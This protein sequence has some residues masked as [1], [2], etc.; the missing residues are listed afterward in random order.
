MQPRRKDN[1]DETRTRNVILSDNINK[2]IKL[3]NLTQTQIAQK[4][5]ISSSML[6]KKI[7]GNLSTFTPEELYKLAKVLNVYVDDLLENDK[8][9]IQRK[10]KSNKEYKP[11]EAR[12]I[13]KVRIWMSV[14]KKPSVLMIVPILLIILCAIFLFFVSKYSAFWGIIALIIPICSIIDF[15]NSIEEE[16]FTI[17]YLDD[18]YYMLDNPKFSKYKY[19]LLIHI[20]QL[21][22]LTITISLFI[23]NV[24]L[25]ISKKYNYALIFCLITTFLCAFICSILCPNIKLKKLKKK[26][27]DFD[28]YSYKKAYYNFVINGV[29]FSISMMPTGISFKNGFICSIFCLVSLCMSILEFVIVSKKFSEYDLYY[30]AYKSSPRKLYPDKYFN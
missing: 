21:V 12:K 22:F 9:K 13:N 24:D 25:N 14:F 17:D 3:S 10:V 16:S 18:V 30:E 28:V 4:L 8:E 19:V 2:Y 11:I 6:S 15:K 5:E 29:I 20:I 26:I 1:V 23:L 7:K 27:Y